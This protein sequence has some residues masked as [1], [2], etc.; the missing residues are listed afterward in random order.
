MISHEESKDEEGV[1][2]LRRWRSRA[3]RPLPDNLMSL[4]R[5]DTHA[6]LRPPPALPYSG[7]LSTRSPSL[8]RIPKGGEGLIPRL[9][10]R[11]RRVPLP[12]GAP[13]EPRMSSIL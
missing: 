11:L 8:L 2:P 12:W 10:M 6:A 4:R 13:G 5:K 3:A 9:L 7:L 1:R